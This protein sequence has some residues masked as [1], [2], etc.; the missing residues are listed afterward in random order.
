MLEQENSSMNFKQGEKYWFYESEETLPIKVTLIEFAE[1]APTLTCLIKGEYSEMTI[2]CSARKLKTI[3]KTELLLEKKIGDLQYIITGL[4]DKLNSIEKLH[5]E[6]LGN[7]NSY[8]AS[9]MET[10]YQESIEKLIKHWEYEQETFKKLWG[11]DG[12]VAY[13]TFVHLTDIFLSNL[14]K[15]TID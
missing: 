12:G 5:Q 4:D 3:S 7:Y 13:N 8:A 9:D 2:W 14:K 15:I 10:R 11:E 6:E 1:N